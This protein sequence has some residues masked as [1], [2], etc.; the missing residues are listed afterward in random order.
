MTGRITWHRVDRLILLAILIDIQSAKECF[1][2]QSQPGGLGHGLKLLMN[3][4]IFRQNF[5]T[6]ITI[7]DQSLEKSFILNFY[8]N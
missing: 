7:F 8:H 2:N 5:Q 3:V 6:K 1:G 4:S